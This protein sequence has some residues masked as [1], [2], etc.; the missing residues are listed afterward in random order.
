MMNGY[1]FI[2][3]LFCLLFLSINLY[4][5][6]NFTV[7]GV[8]TDSTS[9]ETLPGVNVILKGTSHGTTTD[10][11]GHYKINVPSSADTLIFSFVGYKRAVEPVNGRNK[12][13][14][15][16]QTSV[17][18]SEQ[19]VVVGYG[20]QSKRTATGSVSAVS[21]DKLDKAPTVN[22]TQSLAGKMPGLVTI[23]HSGE[24]GHDSATL[25][26]RGQHTLNDNEPL[27][28]IDGVP[29]PGQGLD[30]LSPDDIKNISVL[31]GASAAIYG[32]QAANGVIL[33]TTKRG[34]AGSPKFNFK[35]NQGF[36][37]LT[38]TPNMADA[39]TYLTMLNELNLYRGNPPVYSQQEIQK[40][41]DP[42]SDPWLYPNTDWFAATLKPYS[43]QTKL[44]MSV[45]GG[46]ESIQYRLSFGGLTQ[47][48]AYEN[49][50]T[51]YNQ[52]HFRSNLD[53]Q[54]R[55]LHI[56]F[57]VNGRWEDRNYPT[58]SASQIFE[59]LVKMYPYLPGYWPNGKPGPAFENGENPVIMGTSA[60]GFDNSDT[61]Y[62]S[63]RLNLNL[64]LPVKG[65][66]IRGTGS[67]DKNLI[68]EKR[69][70]KPW[71]LCSLDRAGYKANDGDPTNY[72]SCS[73][74]G[75]DNPELFQQSTDGSNFLANVIGEYARDMGVHSLD[76]M[77]GTEYQH[78]NSA[79]F[80]AFRTNFASD[81]VPQFFAAGQAQ[82]DI[83]GTGSH[84]ARMNF[85]G[86]ANYSYKDKYL[87]EF[88]SRYDG[89]YIFPKGHR[90]GFFPSGSVAWRLTEEK[91]F[92]DRIHFF[93][94]LKIRASYGL[95]GNDRIEPYQYLS[96][97]QFGLG[98][99]FNSD[100]L[101]HTLVP[102]PTPNPNIT[103]E[104]AKKFDVGIEA[105]ILDSRLSFEMD[106]FDE[107]RSK[108]LIQRNASVPL[109][110]GIDLP[111]EN[112]G[113]VRSWGYDGTITWRD[114]ASD[115][116]YN[117]SLNGGYA[118]N[119]IKFWDE[120]PGAPAWQ[121]STGHKMHTNLYYVATG[122]FQDEAQVQ[123]TPHI[124]G[125][126]PGD[127]IFKDVNNDGKITDMDRVRIERNDVPDWTGGITLDAQYK[128]FD[129]SIFF[130][131]AL[132]TSQYVR[133]ASGQF[134]N[135]Y[136][137][138]AEKRWRPD[139]NS[140][141]GMKPDPSGAP[142]SGPRAFNRVE[143]YWMALDN[144]YFYRKTDYLRLKNLQIGYS[145]PK[146]IASKAGLDNMRIY[147]S[148]FNLITWS[149]YKI[150][151]PESAGNIGGPASLA[152]VRG[153]HYPQKRIV[154]LGISLTF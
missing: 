26:V 111:R 140:T 117:I 134:G 49:S 16:L 153:G 109:S 145:L 103:W 85:F 87:F 61:Y 75:I 2:G 115:F 122:I 80:N 51:R 63:T 7:S 27:I 55:N 149:P 11:K 28:V 23:G 32:S 30:R 144:T 3:G 34:T 116:F 136:Q 58:K 99:I 112:L 67:F 48:G 128:N 118:T 37:Q 95:S 36:T 147:I 148:G 152:D 66:S 13:N 18:T 39:P 77:I 31:K 110:A 143:E 19:V 124:Q 12:I 46:D 135:Y 150:G 106:Y 119:K 62:I 104:V 54:I 78:K 10:S 142:Y 24:P 130:Q 59:G 6:N 82:Q 84:G 40:Y 33:V 43:N 137:Q 97:Y 139:P 92:T 73:E 94:N 56:K 69:F 83:N 17:V 101:G 42:N 35:F 8:V 79:F 121:R 1:K 74:Q 20:V 22:T 65:L 76:L 71:S 132:G 47:D 52:Y 14:V 60:T 57:D 45:S 120:P 131:G 108:I 138:F 90:F 21:G 154:N 91:F 89:S 53:G 38:R 72:L 100:Q 15:V 125:A 114:H 127:V 86:R 146:N 81:K 98:Y 29:S 68:Q 126:R 96:T 123:N 105:E 50:A 64:E 70:V 88:D 151:D 133:T 5:Q 44:D 25:R 107:L 41:A 113:K 102:G 93:D 9:G 4:A 141:N 129:F